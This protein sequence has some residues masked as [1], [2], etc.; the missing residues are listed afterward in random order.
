MSDFTIGV[1]MDCALTYDGAPATTISGLGHLEGQEV[2]VLADNSPV[3]GL[4]VKNGEITLPQAASVVHVGL[5]Y[6]SDLETLSLEVEQRDG[7]GQ[8][9]KK[10]VG[11]LVLRLLDSRGLEAGPDA[12]HMTEI[13]WRSGEDYNAPTDL[14]TGD[15]KLVISPQWGT[16]G[17]VFI[18]QSQPLPV[19]ILAVIPE[20]VPGD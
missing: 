10:K 15:K 12:D 13:K 14:F 9:R 20:M 6:E 8:G 5:P 16:D 4:V 3:E 17:R 7:T 18:R 11:Q 1:F 2:V 19:T